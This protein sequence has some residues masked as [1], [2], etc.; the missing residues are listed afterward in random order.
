MYTLIIIKKIHS[1]IK[2]FSLL[3]YKEELRL[4]SQDRNMSDYE[5]KSKEALI[6]VLSETKPKLKPK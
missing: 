3:K 4:I 1:Y 6:K 2:K 5:N